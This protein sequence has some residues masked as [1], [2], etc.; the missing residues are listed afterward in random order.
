MA[1]HL[2]PPPAAAA[3]STQRRLARASSNPWTDRARRRQSRRELGLAG[4]AA[5]RIARWRW[6]DDAVS[7]GK[8]GHRAAESCSLQMGSKSGGAAIRQQPRR[9]QQRKGRSQA[10]AAEAVAGGAICGVRVST[11]WN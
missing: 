3:P 8:K 2:S 4:V 1:L 9:K 7:R 5:G 6:R 10:A 11:G